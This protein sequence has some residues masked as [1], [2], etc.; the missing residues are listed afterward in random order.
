MKKKLTLVLAIAMLFSLLAACAPKEEAT[1]PDPGAQTTQDEPAAPATE[2]PAILE[3][4]DIPEIF[5]LVD[6]PEI[7][8][9]TPIHIMVEASGSGDTFVPFLEKFTEHTGVP[10]TYEMITMADAYAK[11]GAALMSHSGAYDAIMVETTWTNEWKDYLAPLR[12]LAE[13]YDIHGIAGLEADLVNFDQGLLRC[14]TTSEGELMGIPYYSYPL[15]QFIREDVW[16]NEIEQE[17]FLA[18]YGYPLDYATDFEQVR[19][20]AEFFTRDAGDTLKGEVLEHEIY[21]TAQMGGRFTHVQDEIATR[22]WGMGGNFITP[23]RDGSGNITEWV[24]TQN[25]REVMLKACSDYVRDLEFS[26]PGSLNAFWDYCGTQFA[27]G[28]IMFMY[29][30][31]NGLWTWMV[32]DLAANVPGGEVVAIP[33]PGLRPYT[34]GFFFGAVRESQ[35]LEAVYWLSR[36]LVSFE[37][38]YQMPFAGGWPISRFDVAEA[39]LEDPAIDEATYHEALGYIEAQRI[40]SEAQFADINNYIHFNSEAAGR[41]YDLMTNIFHENAI[42]ERTPEETVNEWGRRV[43]EILNRYGSVPAREE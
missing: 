4:P 32:T 35:N 33:V 26:S 6:V 18:K 17:A 9:K 20:Q 19:D 10:V 13:D 12:E 31:Y 5:R 39:A 38:Q 40:T 34:G 2:P 16:K 24:F 8:N 25:D 41:V 11:Q 22:L 21:G 43:V 28:N 23:I 30:Q 27:A 29:A 1:A 42:G 15:M 36:Y 37:A 7:E 3:V 14:A